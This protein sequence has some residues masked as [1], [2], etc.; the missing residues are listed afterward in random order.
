MIRLKGVSATGRRLPGARS[1]IELR[2][3]TLRGAH[4]AARVLLVALIGV[5]NF[6]LWSQS[7]N[8]AVYKVKQEVD[9]TNLQP[10]HSR[11]AWTR[12]HSTKKVRPSTMS[13]LCIYHAKFVLCYRRRRVTKPI[14]PRPSSANED[15]SGTAATSTP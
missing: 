9:T 15:G 12:Y 14:A 5:A 8:H 10:S 7:R 1:E 6:G 3:T 2:R 11:C 13:E 4:P